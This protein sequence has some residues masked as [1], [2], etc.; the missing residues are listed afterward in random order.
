MGTLSLAK[1]EEIGGKLCFHSVG[2]K[3]RKRFARENEEVYVK[4][5]RLFFFC[6]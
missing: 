4:I 1:Q 2:E 3:I 5:H 6:A